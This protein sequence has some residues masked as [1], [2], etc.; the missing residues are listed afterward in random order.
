MVQLS[1]TSV[2]ISEHSFVND[3]GMFIYVC[4]C[5]RNLLTILIYVMSPTINLGMPPGSS[6]LTV[7]ITLGMPRFSAPLLDD[8]LGKDI[9]V[10]WIGKSM[11]EYKTQQLSTKC[12]LLLSRRGD[13]ALSA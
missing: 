9:F 4:I 5:G 7:C 10:V 2:S 3:V 11:L 12:I 13:F 6:S 8:Q 1:M